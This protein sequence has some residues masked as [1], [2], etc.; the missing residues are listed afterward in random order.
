MSKITVKVIEP[1]TIEVFSPDGTSCGRLNETE[2]LD[3]R[4]QIKKFRKSGFYV[5][6]NAN[7]IMIRKDGFMERTIP[8]FVQN[9]RML[10][11]LLGLN[12]NKKK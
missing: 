3:L 6:H 1:E 9:L 10:D 12:K 5:Y 11:Y 8:V 7:K 4:C 2:F